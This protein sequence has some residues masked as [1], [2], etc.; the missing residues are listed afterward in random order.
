[1]ADRYANAILGDASLPLSLRQRAKL[2]VELLTPLL[3]SK[4]QK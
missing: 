1:M 2:L 3:G 4:A